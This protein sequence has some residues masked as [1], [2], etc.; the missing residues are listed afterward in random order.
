MFSL[1]PGIVTLRV[2]DGRLRAAV[3]VGG[4]QVDVDVSA[5][6]AEELGRK[7]IDAAR[8]SRSCDWRFDPCAGP[9][10]GEPS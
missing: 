8:R 6:D 7:L 9:A 2:A 3:Q 10:P 4:L 1:T 5:A